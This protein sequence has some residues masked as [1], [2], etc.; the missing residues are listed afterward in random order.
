VQYL[1]P[2]VVLIVIAV[3]WL[4]RRRIGRG[5]LTALLFFAGTLF[6]A[7][8]FFDVY[9]MLYSFVADHFQYLASVGPISLIAAV[10][11]VAA[12]RYGE[13][14]KVA[15]VG[16]L[17]LILATLGTLTWRQAH[18]YQ[19]LEALW[20]DTLRKNPG[21]WMAHNNLAVL[22]REQGRLD[23]AVEHYH[24]VLRLNE[25]DFIAHTNLGVALQSQGK[26]EEAIAHYRQAL[27][28]EPDWVSAHYNLGTALEAQ[29]RREEALEHFERAVALRPRHA[30]SQYHL[31]GLLK[32]RGDVE[33]AITHYMYAVRVDPNLAE[34][35]RDL[36]IAL[37]LTGR[38]DAALIHFRA[39]LRGRP[40]SVE[41]LVGAAWILA[42][43]PDEAVR[44]P[45]EAVR[46]AG[47]ATMLTGRRDAHVLDTLAAAYAAAGRFD[48]AISTAEKA[49]SLAEGAKRT[50]LAALVST[51]LELY[52]R[53]LPY[54]ETYRNPD[55]MGP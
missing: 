52:K 7:L 10:G 47:R 32:A 25:G 34:A 9:P 19:D 8:G 16:A 50:R 29:G 4:A 55:G 5:P 39:A 38:L 43:H 41:A 54:R 13:H 6:P 26:L 36:G 12:I 44:E 30:H 2:A 21:A 37:M 24:E 20:T 1:F 3:C 17:I 35:H 15:G 28:L 18:T 33:E 45:D 27:Q 46:L 14:A 23:E 40:D 49:L 42:T 53:G 31:A 11:W 22:F 51:R 48:R